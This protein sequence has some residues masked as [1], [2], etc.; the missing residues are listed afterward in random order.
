M[1]DS[2]IEILIIVIILHV[3]L[4]GDQSSGRRPLTGHYVKHVTN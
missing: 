3:M 2:N 1:T 4:A